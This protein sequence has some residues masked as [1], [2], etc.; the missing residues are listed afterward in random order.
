MADSNSQREPLEQLAESFLAQFRAGERP[1]LSEI[2]AAHLE[3]ADQ[4]QALFPALIEMERLTSRPITTSTSCANA[5][6]SRNG[7]PS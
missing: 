4:I 1:S 5:P 6:T 2:T 7:W 3:L